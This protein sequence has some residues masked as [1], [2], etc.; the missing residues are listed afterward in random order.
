MEPCL[1]ING[2]SPHVI[3]N[4]IFALTNSSF[5]QE[6]IFLALFSLWILSSLYLL[7]FVALKAFERIKAVNLCMNVI[8]LPFLPSM[9]TK[10]LKDKI[11]VFGLFKIDVSDQRADTAS[12][13][14]CRYKTER[15]INLSIFKDTLFHK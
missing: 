4:L 6:D 13:N 11:L 14:N 12:T 1:C 7:L 2:T 15:E 5:K 8:K 10:L 3:L 9:S